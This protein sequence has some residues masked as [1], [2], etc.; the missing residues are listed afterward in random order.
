MIQS[1]FRS[2]EVN[3]KEK[4]ILFSEL[5]Q[6]DVDRV[7]QGEETDEKG[8]PYNSKIRKMQYAISQIQIS[9]GGSMKLQYS[10]MFPVKSAPVS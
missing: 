5:L 6:M 3:F 9:G 7:V 8:V 1:K 4:E 2:G 10:P